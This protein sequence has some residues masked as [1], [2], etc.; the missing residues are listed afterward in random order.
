M[1]QTELLHN[2]EEMSTLEYGVASSC[3]EVAGM[4][5]WSFVI[6]LVVLF[7][8]AGAGYLIWRRMQHRWE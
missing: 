4:S 6:L 3:A 2:C 1:G 7:A 5:V 8:V